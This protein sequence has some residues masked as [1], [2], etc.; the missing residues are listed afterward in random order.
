MNGT[1]PMA[2]AAQ[3]R[4][5]GEN[6]KPGPVPRAGCPVAGRWSFL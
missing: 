6:R 3:K 5:A 2:R 1:A 4:M